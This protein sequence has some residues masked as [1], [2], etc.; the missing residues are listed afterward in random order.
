MVRHNGT[1]D[2]EY[3]NTW[4][5][6]KKDFWVA[7]AQNVNNKCR[8][9]FFW[10]L[11]PEKFNSLVVEYDVIWIEEAVEDVDNVAIFEDYEDVLEDNAMFRIAFV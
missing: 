7:L 2:P 4:D 3:H 5:T 9:N 6:S 11:M 1:P 10:W 8:K